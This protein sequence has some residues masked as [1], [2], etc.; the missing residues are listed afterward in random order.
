MTSHC[1]PQMTW[2]GRLNQL[3]GVAIWPPVYRIK[4]WRARKRFG[5]PFRFSVLAE[6]SPLG[7][8]DPCDHT[9]P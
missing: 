4:A 7:K 3:Y 5:M 2:R 8:G 1:R 9:S 6:S